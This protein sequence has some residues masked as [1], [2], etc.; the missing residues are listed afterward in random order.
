[1]RRR[2]TLRPRHWTHLVDDSG[3]YIDMRNHTPSILETCWL[4]IV[5]LLAGGLKGQADQ[6]TPPKRPNFV[7]IMADDLGAKELGC[8]GHPTQRTPNL[9]RLAETGMRFRTCW[10]TPLCSPTRVE[11]LTGRYGFRT[12][13]YNFL[14]RETTP[15]DHLSGDEPTFADMLKS[16]GYAT[17]LA[18]KWQLGSIQK[19]PGMI[20][21]S[22]FDEHCT[23]AWRQLPTDARFD[24]SPRQRYWH[25]AVIQNGKHLPTRPEQYGP[26]VYCDWLIDFIKRN[27]DRPFLAYYPMCLT[28]DPWDPTPDPTAPGGKTK[29]GLKANVEYADTLVGRI[30]RALEQMRLHENTVVFFTGDNGTRKA[31]KGQVTELGARVPLI[32][33]GP[34]LVR[35]GVVS[36]ELVDLSD[37]LPTLAELAGAPLPQGV[38]I[39]GRSFA[40]V[41][42]G[43]K[44]RTREWIFS[45]LAYRRMLRDKRWLLEGDGRFYNCGNSRDGTGYK[46]VTDST[47]PEVI[48]AR[49][50]FEAI[51]T[52]LPAPAKP[53]GRKKGQANPK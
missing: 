53:T 40:P 23:W 28:H 19:H 4:V 42:Q 30:V 44:G 47:N 22:G 3:Y 17:A 1:M 25:P 34:G 46:D 41:L 10:A 9:D 31:G 37:V 39:D 6:P 49:Q 43:R 26:D 29:G 8:Y 16:A 38:T 12:G 13:W 48:A 45:Y 27:K 24:G 18:G 14:G 51:L 15:M 50:R 33:N 2:E 36:D 11:I 52:H 32:V 35:A 7:L 5:V 21:D 20:F